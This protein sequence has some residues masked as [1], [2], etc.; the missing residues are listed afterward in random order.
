MDVGQDDDLK[1]IEE[2]AYKAGAVKHYAID[3]KKDFAEGPI[4]MAIMA[5]ALYEDKYPLGTALARPLIA[6]RSLKWLKGRVVMPWLM[7][8]RPR[9][10]TRSDS[11]RR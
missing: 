1:D 5:N 8:P 9:A 6:R 4:A 7:D 11:M 2:R 10:M 3:A